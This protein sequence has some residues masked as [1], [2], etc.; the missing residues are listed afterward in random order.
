MP[1]GTFA[2]GPYVTPT[3]QGARG[4]GA[5]AAGWATVKMMG[6]RGYRDAALRLHTVH[7]TI[8]QACEQTAG[9]KVVGRSELAIVAMRPAGPFRPL[10]VSR[11][12]RLFSAHRLLGTHADREQHN[13]TS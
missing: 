13:C 1:G 2:G 4:G 8:R 10:L 9:V 5:I 3:L 7:T 11:V 12:S 6:E